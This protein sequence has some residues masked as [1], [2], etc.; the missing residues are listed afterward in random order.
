MKEASPQRWGRAI[1]AITILYWLGIFTLTHLPPVEI[2]KTHI[3][4]KLAHFAVFALLA[5]LLYLSLW[6]SERYTLHLA[7]IVLAI[8][9]IY[10]AVDELTQPLVYRTCS[11]TDWFS[12]VAGGATAIAV[13]SVARVFSGRRRGVRTG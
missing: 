6:R 11:V 8:V 7:G 5:V 1:R 2:P 10:A 13:M 3:S 4:D 9:M 12:D